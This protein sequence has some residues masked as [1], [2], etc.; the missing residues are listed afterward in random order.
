[1][2]GFTRM[3]HP[4]FEALLFSVG[5]ARYGI[6]LDSVAGLVRDLPEGVFESGTE[7]VTVLFD[8]NPVPVFPAG[9]FLPES[10]P[11]TLAPREVILVHDGRGLC[12]MA[13]D[14]TVGVVEVTAGDALYAFPPRGS[15]A[16]SSWRP[17]GVLTVDRRPVILLD[18][19]PATVH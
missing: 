18:P 8:G 3:K 16:G 9:G 12:G 2:R 1:M 17:W 14:S 4:R 5:G 13:V 7:P 6:D 19:V 10:P 15:A 11:R